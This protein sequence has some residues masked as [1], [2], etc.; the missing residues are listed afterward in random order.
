MVDVALPCLEGVASDVALR[1][2]ALGRSAEGPGSTRLARSPLS[3]QRTIVFRIRRNRVSTAPLILR[4]PTRN[5]RRDTRSQTQATV[6]APGAQGRDG[7][8]SA[9]AAML[10]QGIREA[11]AKHIGATL[12]AHQA[13]RNTPRS[14]ENAP[15]GES[16]TD[17]PNS[18]GNWRGSD[19]PGGA[20]A[21]AAPQNHGAAKAGVAWRGRTRPVSPR[22]RRARR[23]A[24]R[25]CRRRRWQCRTG[26]TSMPRA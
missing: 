1:P 21:G 11:W 16:R 22:A 8:T 5:A 10:R 20:K 15:P 2:A 17:A 18:A 13:S 24:L 23:T 6:G 25:R 12:P 7:R 14:R 9:I 3:D 4:S 26:R 19:G